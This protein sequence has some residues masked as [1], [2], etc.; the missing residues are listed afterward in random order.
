[1]GLNQLANLGEFIGGI[2][3]LVTLVY[4]TVQVR[5]ARVESRVNTQRVLDS[6]LANFLGEVAKDEDLHRIWFNGLYQREPLDELEEDRLGMLLYQCFGLYS[7]FYHSA[8]LNP[9]VEQ[10]FD[11]LLDR[12][13]S[14]PPV[15]AW[16]SRQREFHPEAFRVHVDDRLE[17]LRQRSEQ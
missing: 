6:S 14:L 4:L 10:S 9:S 15:Q 8:V 17:G 12:T 7:T 3:V 16:W 11:S 13:L 5:Q 2:A 1:M